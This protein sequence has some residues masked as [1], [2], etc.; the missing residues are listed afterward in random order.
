VTFHVKQVGD[1]TR[2]LPQL[3]NPGGGQVQRIETARDERGGCFG[4][5]YGAFEAIL[6]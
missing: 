1:W 4:G 2:A 6:A 5:V 3:F